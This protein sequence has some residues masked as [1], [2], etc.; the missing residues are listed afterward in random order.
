MALVSEAEE[1][2]DQAIQE[3]R[4]MSYLLHP[5]LLDEVGFGCAAEWYIE[6]LLSEAD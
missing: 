5:P 3:I 4:T 2:T 1:L 6:A